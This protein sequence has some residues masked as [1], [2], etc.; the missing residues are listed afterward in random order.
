MYYQGRNAIFRYFGS[1]VPGRKEIKYSAS[2]IH[3]QPA[4]EKSFSAD[5]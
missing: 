1:I 5:I 2:Y 4:S 3:C